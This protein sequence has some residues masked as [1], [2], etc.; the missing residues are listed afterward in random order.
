MQNDILRAVGLGDEG[1]TMFEERESNLPM[2]QSYWYDN[3]GHTMAKY[4]YNQAAFIEGEK[5]F[6]QRAGHWMYA[7]V[8][9]NGHE[10]TFE[11]V[12]NG[13][14]P[15]EELKLHAARKKYLEDSFKNFDVFSDKV[16]GQGG[17]V[18]KPGV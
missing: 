6:V 18:S 9:S 16:M 3:E 12:E 13:F 2:L 4:K 8:A 7:P 10:P 14:N 15:L 5:R 11:F 17:E 1:N